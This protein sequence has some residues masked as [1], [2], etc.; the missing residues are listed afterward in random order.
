MTLG[1]GQS[2]LSPISHHWK[3]GVLLPSQGPRQPEICPAGEATHLSFDKWW[4][5]LGRL[6]E[7]MS[8]LPICEGCHESVGR[9]LPMRSRPLCAIRPLP[10]SL[11]SSLGSD[12][13]A[14]TDTL[15]HPLPG[16]LLHTPLPPHPPPGL[17][18]S[19]SLTNP[20]PP[21]KSGPHSTSSWPFYTS[22]QQH[23]S[24]FR[25]YLELYYLFYIHFLNRKLHEITTASVLFLSCPRCTAPGV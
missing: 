17:S 25:S 14:Q 16:Q 11:A 15:P 18:S 2:L 5:V 10:L 12:P 20:P 9:H 8:R 19:G 4:E 6:R 3:V 13:W 21:S 24:Q 7:D 1:Q 23:W 22:L